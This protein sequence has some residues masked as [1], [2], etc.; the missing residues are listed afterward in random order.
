MSVNQLNEFIKDRDTI[1]SH[2]DKP[3]YQEIENY[4]KKYKIPMPSDSITI[5]AGLHKARLQV[6]TIPKELKEKS[7]LWL[8]ENGFSCDIK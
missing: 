4:C 7:K 5:L 2:L 3:D 1:L 8:K 6:T